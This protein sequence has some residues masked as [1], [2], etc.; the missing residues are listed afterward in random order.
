MIL[1]SNRMKG[2]T[3]YS[4]TPVLV[5]VQVVGH[6][7]CIE[8]SQSSSVEWVLRDRNH[9]SDIGVLYN[10]LEG[11]LHTSGCALRQIDLGGVGRVSIALSDE[12]GDVVADV[13]NA[14]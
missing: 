3:T 6:R 4:E 10:H 13:R 7:A 11:Q 2:Q 9:D 14:L 1:L 8:D 5:L 12:L